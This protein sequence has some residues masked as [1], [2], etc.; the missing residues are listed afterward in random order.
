MEEVKI[1]TWSLGKEDMEAR[2]G[3]SVLRALLLLFFF[4]SVF[5][6]SPFPPSLTEKAFAEEK[7]VSPNMF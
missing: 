2:S 1:S 6:F 4:F 7:V 5:M 3:Y